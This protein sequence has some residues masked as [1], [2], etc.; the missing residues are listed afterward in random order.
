MY[1]VSKRP[2]IC[3]VDYI[4]VEIKALQSSRSLVFC[5]M[6]MYTYDVNEIHNS[7]VLLDFR[8]CNVVVF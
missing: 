5:S 3:Y 2:E 8:L 4:R 6:R 7:A 1:V